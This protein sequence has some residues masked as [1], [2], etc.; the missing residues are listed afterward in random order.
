MLPPPEL[1]GF[2]YSVV[3]AGASPSEMEAVRTALVEAEIPAYDAF[4]PEIMDVIA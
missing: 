2:V 1:A 3:E 4:P